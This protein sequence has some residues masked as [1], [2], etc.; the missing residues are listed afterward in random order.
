[1]TTSTSTKS[2]LQKIGFNL[3]ESMGKRPVDARP[4][5]SPVVSPKDVGRRPLR[6]FGRVDIDQVIPDPAQPR[7]DFATEA[8]ERLAQSIRE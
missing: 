5:L 4:Q 2:L 3:D 1:M 7:S 8:V 6:T